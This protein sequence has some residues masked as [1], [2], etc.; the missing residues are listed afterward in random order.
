MIAKR[1]LLGADMVTAK[2]DIERYVGAGRIDPYALTLPHFHNDAL[3]A[4]VTGGVVGLLAW[5]SILAAPLLFFWRAL[6]AEATPARPQAALALAGML[7]V[8]SYFAFGLSEVIFWSVKGSLFY[9]LMVFLLMGL[10]LNAKEID[11]K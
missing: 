1:P 11:G 9:A 2:A 7:V 3:Q 10:C 4:L 5:L 8:V 6:R